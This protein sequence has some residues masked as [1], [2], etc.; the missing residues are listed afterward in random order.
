M[1]H[2][3]KIVTSF[4]K[5]LLYFLLGPVLFL[6]IMVSMEEEEIIFEKCLV[7]S[8]LEFFYHHGVWIYRSQPFYLY[9][10]KK[11]KKNGED[12]LFFPTFSPSLTKKMDLWQCSFVV[13]TI[14]V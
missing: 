4:I 3:A 10:G 13:L 8:V 14:A 7:K 5:V 2:L 6:G 11:K 1:L 9:F 12:L